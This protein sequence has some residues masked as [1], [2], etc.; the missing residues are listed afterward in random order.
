MAQLWDW[1]ARP[2]CTHDVPAKP[3][4][5]SIPVKDEVLIYNPELIEAIVCKF[6]A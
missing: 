4:V 6:V 3:A 2:T 1:T 5:L